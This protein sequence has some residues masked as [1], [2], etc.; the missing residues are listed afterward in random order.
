MREVK[1]AGRSYEEAARWYRKAADQGDSL[2]QVQHGPHLP[3]GPRCA[4]GQG[5]GALEVNGN[6]RIRIRPEAQ[7]T[8][9]QS[10][11]HRRGGRD[12]LC[13]SG[14]MAAQGS[15]QGYVGALNNLGFLYEHG[16]GVTRDLKE[17]AKWYRAAAEKNDPQAQANLGVITVKAT[18]C[19]SGS[20]SSLQMAEGELMQGDPIGRKYMLDYDNGQWEMTTI[21]W[22]SRAPGGG[23]P[24]PSSQ[25]QALTNRLLSLVGSA[26]QACDPGCVLWATLVPPWRDSSTPLGWSPPGHPLTRTQFREGMAEPAVPLPSVQSLPQI[27]PF[28]AEPFATAPDMPD[29]LDPG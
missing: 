7:S 28:P 11:P 12:K 15:Q 18:K 23:I 2:T 20:C 4:K 27:R 24:G 9:G 25:E 17:A 29:R 14:A 10:V 13:E 21:K 22:P 16:M 6:P 1:T 26:G 3:A 19:P 8:F 5:R